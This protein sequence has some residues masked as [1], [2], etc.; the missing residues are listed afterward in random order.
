MTLQEELELARKELDKLQERCP[1][2]VRPGYWSADIG[3]AIAWIRRV[4]AAIAEQEA[5][6]E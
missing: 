2:G 3:A 1:S 6:G 4:E 5:K